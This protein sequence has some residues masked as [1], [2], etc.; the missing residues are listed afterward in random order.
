LHFQK[1]P[2]AQAKLVRVMRGAIFDVAVD[3]RRDSPSFG[4]WCA[5]T[6][7]A[8]NDEEIFVPHGFAHGF[9]TLEDGTEVAYKVDNYYAAESEG[10]IIWNDP[11]IGIK[12]PIEP[13]EAV[14]SHKDAALPQLAASNAPFEYNGGK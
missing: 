13:H 2:H 10:G 3:I 7:S 11:R 6:L 4:N 14:L 5:A 8:I 9:C 1:P 12:W